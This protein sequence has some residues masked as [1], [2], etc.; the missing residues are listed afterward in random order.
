VGQ[1]LLTG[2]GEPIGQG[3]E[4]RESLS[5]RITFFRSVEIGR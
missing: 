2:Q 4:H 3:V 1:V 5:W